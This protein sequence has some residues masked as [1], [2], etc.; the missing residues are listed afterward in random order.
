MNKDEFFISIR[1]LA[2]QI[3]GFLSKY[4]DSGDYEADTEEKCISEIELFLCSLYVVTD[5]IKEM[6]QFEDKFGDRELFITEVQP[7]LHRLH[8]IQ[9]HLLTLHKNSMN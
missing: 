5:T 9:D 3:Y 4:D 7:I 1:T 6:E 2:E 8:K